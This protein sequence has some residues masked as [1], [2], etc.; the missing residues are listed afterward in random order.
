MSKVFISGITG[1][2]G[3]AIAKI[4][5]EKGDEVVGCARD[6]LRYIK[7]L[8]NNGKDL[9]EVRIACISDLQNPTSYTYDT[10]KDSSVFYHCAAMKHVDLCEQNLR[11]AYKQNIAYTGLACNI[12]RALNIPF[13]F[14]S[15]D[16]ACMPQSAYGATK[17]LAEKVVLKS[18]GSVVRLGNLI[19][20]SGSVFQNWIG[21]I[22]RGEKIKITDPHMTRYFIPVDE[23]ARFVIDNSISGVIVA[24]GY[25]KSAVIGAIAKHILETNG[26]EK[27]QDYMEVIGSKEGET[28]HQYIVAPGDRV[29]FSKLPAT[30]MIIGH[31]DGSTMT[32]GMTSRTAPKWDIEELLSHVK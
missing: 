7:W 14:I 25:M 5:K 10:L 26:I 31:K 15:S 22:E 18:G 29:F 19:G 20:S 9:A 21:A 1:T 3:T 8:D 23:A 30:Y 13:V 4:H 24:P 17:F 16:K 32:Y 2:L 12:S 28:T 27:H 6:E 11:Q